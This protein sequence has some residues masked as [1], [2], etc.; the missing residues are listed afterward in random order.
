MILKNKIK[1]LTQIWKEI[2][3]SKNIL[4]HLHPSPDADSAGG[5]LSFMHVLKKLKKNV[6][7]I[8]GDSDFPQNLN[9]LP[10]SD[11]ILA[12]NIFQIDLSKFDLFIA[13]DTASLTQ[14]SKQGEV[15]FPKNLKTITIDHHDTNTNFSKIN[16]IDTAYP[17]TCQILFDV[18]EYKNIKI[19]KDI[20]SCLFAGI[21]T[22]T[23]GFKYPKTT[24]YTFLVAS[25]LAKIAPKFSKIIFEM[26]NNEDPARLKY[27]SIILSSVETFL[28][29]QVAIASISFDTIQKNNLSQNV[30]S[31]SDVANM[32][33]SVVSWN[34]GVCLI[35]TQPDLVKLSFR[36]RD[37]NKFDVA[38][39]AE[40]LGGGG[41]KAAAG[42][43]IKKPLPE[44][45]NELLK[46]ISSVY[47]KLSK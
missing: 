41:L 22:D 28:Q 12:K 24:D 4:F 47:P 11:K 26:E 17:A 18:Y 6:T 15:V 45:K 32:L 34:I 29:D 8:S 39:I 2:D 46:A 1:L 31:T 25:K 40:K 42:A 35:E 37:A 33:K 5:A 30:I 43:T 13:L 44:A 16:F 10:G 23:G 27:L 14:I 19:N 20:A 36:T 9:S 38:K 7:V 3:N 21:Y